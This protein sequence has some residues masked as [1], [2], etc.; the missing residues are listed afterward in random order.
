M[1]T[2][3][4]FMLLF[5]HEIKQNYKHSAEEA[6][7][8]LQAWEVFI[9]DIAIREK[10]VNTYQLGFAGKQISAANGTSE[11][12]Y[13]AGNQIVGGNMVIKAYTIEEAIGLAKD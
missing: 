11:S 3:K 6:N 1:E 10:L 7:A 2:S 12:F 4:E 8:Q 5:R 13:V 9:G